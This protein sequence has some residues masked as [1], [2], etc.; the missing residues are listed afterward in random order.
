[1]LHGAGG[2]AERRWRKRG[3]VMLGPEDRARP[4]RYRRANH[5]TEVLRVLDL[6]E[7]EDNGAGIAHLGRDG[8]ERDDGEVGRV[9]RG[10]LVASSLAEPI[11]IRPRDTLDRGSAI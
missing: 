1:M 3:G 8:I 4:E 2:R 9:R 10:S 5:R 7:R 6:V 11:E